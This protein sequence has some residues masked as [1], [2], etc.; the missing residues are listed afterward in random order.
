MCPELRPQ[1]PRQFTCG[2][3]TI[4]TTMLMVM[5]SR[6]WCGAD[7]DDDVDDDDGTVMT[8]MRVMK[9]MR[10]SVQA[11]YLCR[12]IS[13]EQHWELPHQHQQLHQH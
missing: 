12:Q 2:G 10:I 7:G 5:V 4:T 3:T 11:Q 13:F 6:W 8:S 9:M 1:L